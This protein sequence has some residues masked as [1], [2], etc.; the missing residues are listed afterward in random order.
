MNSWTTDFKCPKPAK[1]LVCQNQQNILCP[2]TLFLKTSFRKTWSYRASLRFTWELYI[3]AHIA[4]LVCTALCLICDILTKNQDILQPKFPQ[5]KPFCEIIT[6]HTAEH[7]IHFPRNLSPLQTPVGSLLQVVITRPT[8]LLKWL[9]SI[10]K[11]W[12]CFLG[13]WC[14]SNP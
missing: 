6:T 5:Q 3:W 13:C 4:L 2:A 9:P 7:A 11:E 12:F 1:K 10:T 14:S 8:T